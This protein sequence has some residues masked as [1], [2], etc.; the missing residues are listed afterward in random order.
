MEGT[1]PPPCHQLCGNANKLMK[2][3]ET[4]IITYST[5][6]VLLLIAKE[7][8]ALLLVTDELS[9][10]S[11][12]KSSPAGTLLEPLCMG[13]IHYRKPLIFSI[14]VQYLKINAVHL[15]YLNMNVKAAVSN[16]MFGYTMRLRLMKTILRLLHG[17]LWMQET[18]QTFCSLVRALHIAEG[19]L[20]AFIPTSSLEKDPRP[21]LLLILLSPQ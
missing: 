7:L 19:L 5:Y 17:I 10:T 8:L 12:N 11:Y 15:R 13:W 6:F 1:M 2:T 16:F 20:I 14:Q 3:T 18:F 4:T 9:V 21:S